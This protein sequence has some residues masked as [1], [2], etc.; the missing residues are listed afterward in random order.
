MLLVFVAVTIAMM[1]FCS[2]RVSYLCVNPGVDLKVLSELIEGEMDLNIDHAEPAGVWANTGQ[3]RHSALPF[4]KVR[5]E[6][7]KSQLER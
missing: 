1:C 4:L 7:L 5:I 6:L 3:D 2:R